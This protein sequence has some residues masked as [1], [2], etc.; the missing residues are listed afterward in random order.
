MIE[1]GCDCRTV[2]ESLAT[3]NIPD[4]WC[5][6]FD[7]CEGLYPIICMQVAQIRKNPAVMDLK[8]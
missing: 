8:L 6:E 2:G 7:V 4:N 5:A 3:H 1:F